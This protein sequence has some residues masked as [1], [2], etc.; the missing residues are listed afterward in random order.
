MTAFETTNIYEISWKLRI[1]AS[2]KSK[3][4]AILDSSK[5]AVAASV[6]AKFVLYRNETKTA[7]DILSNYGQNFLRNRKTP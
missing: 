3:T 1:P 7:E 5:N 6:H 4:V 2:Q